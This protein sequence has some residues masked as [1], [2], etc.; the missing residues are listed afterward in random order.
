MP[1]AR[2]NGIVCGYWVERAAR[3]DRS[4]LLITMKGEM[5]RS[6]CHDHTE[7]ESGIYLLHALFVPAASEVLHLLLIDFYLA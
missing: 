5:P 7:H 6:G 1:V 4:V 3:G 2:G